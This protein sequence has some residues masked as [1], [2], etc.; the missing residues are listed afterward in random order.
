M[1]GKGWKRREKNYR[2][3]HGGYIRLPPP[4][5]SSAIDVMPSKLRK[6]MSFTASS[7]STPG[8]VKVAADTADKRTKGDGGTGKK[9]RQNDESKASMMNVEDNDGRGIA[10]QDTDDDDMRKKK[11]AK[12][13]RK[14][15][16]DLRFEKQLE[17]LGVGSKRRDRKKKY[18]EERKKKHKKAESEEPHMEFPGREEIKFGEVV[19]APLKLVTVPKAFKNVQHASTERL[20]LQAVEAYR[21]RKGW[22]SRPG[23]DLPSPVTTQP[24]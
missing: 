21:N 23:L 1:V 12:R 22:A 20:R 15:V 9:L 19:E 11:K 7:Q 16:N 3:A 2:A 5:N 24:L 13:K 4:P 6:L 14:Q 18:M 17:E 10:L 8:S